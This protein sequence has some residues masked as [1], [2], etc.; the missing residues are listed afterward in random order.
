MKKR[1]IR[2]NDYRI[3]GSYAILYLNKDQTTT[4]SI[5]DLPRVLAA[6][7]WS[8]SWNKNAN[9]YYVQGRVDGKFARLHKFL[10]DNPPRTML[11]DHK[12]G[13]S[14]N[15]CKDNLRLVTKKQNAENRTDNRSN[16]DIR[17]ISLSTS[18]E[19]ASGKCY[20][21]RIHHNGKSYVKEK[22]VSPHNLQLLQ[23]WVIAKRLELFTH[24]DGR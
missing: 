4:V 5:D 12:D 24:S 16:T 20:R 7:R 13:N 19:Y 3:E 1:P 17:N 15:N 8:V 21:A 23:E 18:S 22:A 11:V 2:P 6:S 10:M 14:L 9:R